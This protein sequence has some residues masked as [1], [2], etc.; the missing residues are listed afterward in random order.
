MKV[1]Q[2]Y[3]LFGGIALKN[4]KFSFLPQKIQNAFKD[5]VYA[6]CVSLFLDRLVPCNVDL[7]LE[8]FAMWAIYQS[9]QFTLQDNSMLYC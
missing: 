6:G 5:A 3:E 1:V 2:C 4:H 7:K 8:P 9:C